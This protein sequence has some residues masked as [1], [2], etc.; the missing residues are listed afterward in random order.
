VQYDPVTLKVTL[1]FLTQ[2]RELE[3]KRYQKMACLVKNLDRN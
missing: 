3:L 1:N 2:F